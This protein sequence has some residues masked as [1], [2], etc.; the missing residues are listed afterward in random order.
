MLSF[1]NQYAGN[2]HS[3]NGEDLLTQEAVKRIGLTTGH[4]VEIGGNDGFWMSNT[5]YLIEQGWSGL[6]V[7]F[8]YDLYLK[9]KQNWAN[10]PKVRS[11]CSR[12]DGK[13]INAFVDDSCDVLSLDTD[14]SDFEIF[15]GL[16]AKPKIVIVEIDSSIPP[17]REGFNS[18]GGAGYF[19]MA[20]LALEKG[21]FVLAHTGN[22]VLIDER[23]R[24]LFPEVKS[25]HPLIDSEAYFNRNWLK[26]VAA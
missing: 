2:V 20:V 25:K 15:K 11:Q 7:E 8:Q 23:Y 26:D 4:C 10:N 21:Y 13:N 1:L 12:V 24:D 9:C 6:F 22:L 3:Q 16:K 5:R 19:S 18:D 17:D 14:G